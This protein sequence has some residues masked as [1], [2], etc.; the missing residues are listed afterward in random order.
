MKINKDLDWKYEEKNVKTDRNSLVDVCVDMVR[1]MEAFGAMAETLVNYAL[2]HDEETEKISEKDISPKDEVGEDVDYDCDD[3]LRLACIRT[4]LIS[5]YADE[6]M[7]AI[8]H[9]GA[10][11]VD[12]PELWVYE[13]VREMKRLAMC[14]EIDLNQAQ[15]EKYLH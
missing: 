6:V 3:E 14:I 1:V 4:R 5:D 10:E 12:N 9:G 8:R 15:G 7:D 11:G 2:E 13:K